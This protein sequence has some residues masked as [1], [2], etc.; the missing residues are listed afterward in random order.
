MLLKG[1]IDF[2]TSDGMRSFTLEVSENNHTAIGLYSGM[3]F[4][5]RASGMGITPIP[6]RRDIMWL[7]L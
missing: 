3:G 2:G 6:V 5:K 1:M 4:V 7:E